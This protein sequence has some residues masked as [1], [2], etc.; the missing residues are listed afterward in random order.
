MCSAQKPTVSVPATPPSLSQCLSSDGDNR[1]P[2]AG[3]LNNKQISLSV[4]RPGC[5]RP[6]CRQVWFRWEP[7]SWPTDG[8]LPGYHCTAG[9]RECDQA[10]CSPYK[11]TNPVPEGCTL[12]VSLPP[13]AIT[14]GFVISTF[15]SC[16]DTNIQS[17]A[18]SLHLRPLEECLR[19]LTGK[20]NLG[21]DYRGFRTVCGLD[22]LV[23]TLG[24]RATLP[25]SLKE[26]DPL[27]RTETWA[28]R[29]LG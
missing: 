6:R 29:G 14:K 22:P 28:A 7:A 15:E 8:C 10:D 12:Q 3:W 9:S 25:D 4:W 26:R 18:P 20:R 23:H 16:W 5:P 2:Q 19:L 17:E 13:N 1:L 11:G 24:A 21:V 27:R